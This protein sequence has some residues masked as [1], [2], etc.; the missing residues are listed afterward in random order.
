M[1]T[2]VSYVLAVILQFMSL[3]TPAEQD[4][5][6]VLIHQQCDTTASVLSDSLFIINNEQVLKTNFKDK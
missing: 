4:N 3:G 2:L 6:S 1:S 5:I